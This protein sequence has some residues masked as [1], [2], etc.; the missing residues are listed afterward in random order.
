V[1]IRPTFARCLDCHTDEHGGQLAARPGKGECGDCHKVAGWKPSTFDRGAHARLRLPLDGRHADI[2]CQACH[3]L[4]RKELPPLPK[5]QLGEAGFFF[6][7]T[8]VECTA[9][10]LDPHKGRFAAGGPRRKERGCAA[11]HDARAFQPSTADVATHATFG[12]ALEGAHRATACV[13][14][15]DELKAG[16]TGRRSSLI[17]SGDSSKELRFESKKTGCAE[18]HQTPHGTQFDGRPDRGRCDACHTVEA[19][20][21]AG[22]FNHDRDASFALKGAHEGVPCN[23]CHPS[24]LKSGNPKSL[25]FRPI[26]GKCESCH[27]KESR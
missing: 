27:D 2:E 26:S 13:A 22:K 12:F 3:G 14:C 8:E 15:H 5:A 24:D 19:F 11:C 16:G 25:I 18:C 21:P 4:D 6:K 17:R 1:V 20:A 10:H 23:Q 9:C 7:V